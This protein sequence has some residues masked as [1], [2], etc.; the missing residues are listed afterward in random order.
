[1]LE[2]LGVEY[3]FIKVDLLTGGGQTNEYLNIH[4]DGKVPAIDDE[5][6][7]LTE[8]AAI[9]SYLGDKY[10]ESKLIPEPKTALRAKYDE[11]CFYILTELEQPLWTIGK[12]TFVFPEK[13]RVPEI[14]EIA[15]WEFQK[16]C[17]VLQKKLASNEYAMAGQFSAI[18]ILLTH[19]L[20]WAKAFAVPTGSETLDK[21]RDNHCNRTAFKKMLAREA[22]ES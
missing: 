14:L 19:T 15:N 9:V 10:S 6:F 2:E 20:N 22:G 11:W 17:K 4:A 12:H 3:E 1:M 18:D 7:I 13:K 21:Y 8:S 16:A 5:G